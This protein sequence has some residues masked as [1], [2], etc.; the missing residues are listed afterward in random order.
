METGREDTV[1]SPL[2][3]VSAFT[4]R[5]G[6]RVCDLCPCPLQLP[7]GRRDEPGPRRP[8]HPRPHGVCAIPGPAQAL[9]L[10]AA[11]PPQPPQQEGA[12]PHDDAPRTRQPLVVHFSLPADESSPLSTFGQ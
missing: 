3:T 8:A 6:H 4:C 12:A 9:C 7:G 5:I 1:T 10:P 2:L 11:G